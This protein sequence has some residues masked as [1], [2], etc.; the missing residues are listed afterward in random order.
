MMVLR[1]SSP[2]PI[3]L[4]RASIPYGRPGAHV[5]A[6]TVGKL[7]EG[8]CLDEQQRTWSGSGL[9]VGCGQLEGRCLDEQQRT[10]AA[11]TGEEGTPAAPHTLHQHKEVDELVLDRAWRKL[12]EM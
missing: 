2:R 11:A 7:E 12:K 6:R 10:K 9:A 3:L 4:V 5:G 8:R 1:S